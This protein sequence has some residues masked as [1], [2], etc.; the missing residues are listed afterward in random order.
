MARFTYIEN[1]VTFIPEFPKVTSRQ[2]TVF[3][4]APTPHKTV[5]QTQEIR[6]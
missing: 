4:S 5:K 3:L 1:T 6:R 2:I